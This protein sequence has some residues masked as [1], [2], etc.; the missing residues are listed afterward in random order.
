MLKTIGL[1]VI[2]ISAI[3]VAC[4]ELSK[5]GDSTVIRPR[6]PESPV[7]GHFIFARN[8]PVSSGKITV[9]K[10]PGNAI[11]DFNIE[12]ALPRGLEI[13]KKTGTI[14]GT[15]REF[16]PQKSY[17]I[18]YTLEI[19]GSEHVAELKL[20]VRKHAY[21]PKNRKELQ[22]TIDHIAKDDANGY[23]ADFSHIDTSKIDN[24]SNLFDFLPPGRSAFSGDI[25]DWDVSNVVNM[26]G[27][28]RRVRDFNG[29]ISGWDVSSVVNM[30]GMFQGVTA[31][32]GD[33]SD[34]RPVAVTD[35]SSMFQGATTFNRDISGWDV[36]SVVNMSGMFQGAA[37][38]NGDVS[39]WKPVAVTD[40]S[41]M[42]QGATTFN[43]DVSGWDVGSVVNMSGMFQGAAAF[44]GDVS[45]WKPVAVID[46]S[47]MFQ[48]ATTFNRDVSGWRPV[49]V[50]DM[51]SMFRDAV[52]FNQDLEDWS[53]GSGVKFDDIFRNS[54]IEQRNI[55][56]W[57]MKIT[58][59]DLYIQGSRLNAINDVTFTK[60]P[61]D[62]RG[63]Y[64]TN[65]ALPDGLV[66]DPERGT[67]SGVPGIQVSRTP[68]QVI[69]TAA[70]S[71]RRAIADLD[72]EVVN[73]THNPVNKS[74]LIAAIN[75]EIANQGTSSPSLNIIYTGNVS[76]MSELFDGNA[77]FD[78]DISGWN[79]GRVTNMSGMF[80]GATAFNG[81]ISG[82][83]VGRVTNMSGMFQ[84]ATAFN[85]NISDWDVGGVTNM[86][87]MFRGATAFNRNISDWDVGGVTNMSGMFQGAVSFNRNISD[88]DVD[89]VTDISNMFRSATAFSQNLNRW[90]IDVLNVN[91]RNIFRDSGMQNTP[92]DWYGVEIIPR[93]DRVI[94]YIPHNPD[95]DTDI[96]VDRKPDAVEGVYSISP[97]LP[98]DMTINPDSGLISGSLTSPSQS[99][100]S[101]TIRFTGTG[102]FE[103]MVATETVLI[104]TYTYTYSPGDK[105]ELISAINDEIARQGTDSPDLNMINTASIRDMS[106][107]FRDRVH[108]N[109]DMYGWNM[110]S[111]I[112]T[113]NM[114]REALA[115]NGD[116]SRWDMANV[117]DA[118]GMFRGAR[119]FNRD[120]SG[121]I[122]GNITTMH[123]MFLYAFVFNQDISVWDVSNVKDM[124]GMFHQ[125]RAFNQDI[126]GWDVK[127]VTKYED[128]RYASGLSLSNTPPRFR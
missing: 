3:L 36:G 112:T 124:Y 56:S 102:N 61:T 91:T 9:Y 123:N 23:A 69:F 93:E 126:S 83:N 41:S 77:T 24:M 125:A 26:S 53:I 114:F 128:F 116:I 43:R 42:F 50:T 14:S 27:M 44:N 85:R 73:Y 74:E 20:E 45:G 97:E 40:M 87:G 71:G 67:I 108:F 32:N 28:F 89:R 46:M 111:V 78:G 59:S 33:I 107:L 106:Y 47:S 4:E 118:S 66:I 19:N 104:G 34:W 7:D 120:I 1:S 58:P 22:R 79:V 105:S 35:M 103:G 52:A 8:V 119:S 18:T 39:G 113:S 15:P 96:I 5:L 88:W 16:S 51:S 10:I 90:G 12:P 82:W 86:S 121:W 37:A 95:F 70:E 115:F 100:V 38:F 31:F 63:T 21:F 99:T 109:G 49:A 54:S 68:W 57:Y 25:S 2:V 92:P 84:G 64:S 62:M 60:R 122:T 6:I 94:G 127:K 75:S 80:R 65:P 11:G 81:D 17:V 30:S 29:D 13:D 55:P 101:H 98:E 117:I 76:D 110:S 48:G 72:V